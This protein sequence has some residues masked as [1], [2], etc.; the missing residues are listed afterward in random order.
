MS[1]LVLVRGGTV[2][3]TEGRLL[4]RSNEELSS[5]GQ[6]QA[7][8]AA[9]LLLDLKVDPFAGSYKSREALL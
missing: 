1:R 9:E 2:G 3:G 5:L 8:K 4:G 6:A 7:R